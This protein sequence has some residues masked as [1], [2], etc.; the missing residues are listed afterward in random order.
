MALS[1]KGYDV[2]ATDKAIIL[3]L[4]KENVGIFSDKFQSSIKGKIIV[5]QLDW[6]QVDNEVT[7]SVLSGVYPDLILCSDCLYSSASVMP[8]LSVL[9]KVIIIQ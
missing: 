5:K 6:V 4:L 3:D 2:I 7:E 8:L 1:L 9:E